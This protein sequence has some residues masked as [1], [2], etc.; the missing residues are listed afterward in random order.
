MQEAL[1]CSPFLVCIVL[2]IEGDFMHPK[3]ILPFLLCVICI[4]LGM[5]NLAVGGSSY[6]GDIPPPVF[7]VDPSPITFPLTT[8]Q[9]GQIGEVQISYEPGAIVI[10]L[11]LSEEDWYFTALYLTIQPVLEDIPQ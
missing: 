4:E 11:T 10:D 5:I 7:P 1:H 3:K 8:I 2:S 6:R 9:A